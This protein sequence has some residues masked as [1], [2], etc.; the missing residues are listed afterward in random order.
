MGPRYGINCRLKIPHPIRL[1]VDCGFRNATQQAPINVG[2]EWASSKMLT[3]KEGLYDTRKRRG[4]RSFILDG[5]GGRMFFLQENFFGAPL[6]WVAKIFDPPPPFGVYYFRTT[7]LHFGKNLNPKPTIFAIFLCPL[8]KG[9]NIFW[10]SPFE[11]CTTFGAPLPLPTKKKLSL[12]W[13]RR[14]P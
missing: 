1:C 14:A 3:K 5:G 2:F 7:P 4:G 6:T 9:V 13:A 8:R 11:R 12:L 10:H